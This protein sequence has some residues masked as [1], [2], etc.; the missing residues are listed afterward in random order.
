M[1]IGA[2]EYKSSI[3]LDSLYY[4]LITVDCSTAYT[5]GTPKVL[6]PAAELNA[7]PATEQLTQYADD[8]AYDVANSEGETKLSMVVTGIPMSALAE[9]TG[10]VYDTLNGVMF[11]NA[12]SPPYC[13]LI[14]RSKKS[15]GKYR[16]YTYLK[17]KF[18]KPKDGFK[19]QADKTEFQP[20]TLE[21]T[22][23]KTTFKWPITAQ[24]TD[25]VKRII[26][27]TDIA[28]F[29]STDWFT[30]VCTPPATAGASI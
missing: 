17:G 14:F 13:A 30:A 15:N 23:V 2:D 25:S 27:D 24:L 1:T 5:A 4:A 20:Q 3:G 7:E 19:T 21:F 18:S 28:A 9:I 6:A 29:D 12:G 8:Q 11:D 22:A 16:Y 26:G 10:C